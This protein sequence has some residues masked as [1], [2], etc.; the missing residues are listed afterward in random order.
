[1]RID[2]K[3]IFLRKVKGILCNQKVHK[4]FG[5]LKG[6]PIHLC[7]FKA[8]HIFINY[9]MK[10]ENLVDFLAACQLCFHIVLTYMMIKWPIII[11]KMDFRKQRLPQL[12]VT[13]D[14]N[15]DQVT[16]RQFSAGVRH[17]YLCL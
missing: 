6:L 8:A 2:S 10:G 4:F 16:H 14:H 9:D 12:V 11:I 7:C 13:S 15:I 17:I 1:M 3:Y 5:G